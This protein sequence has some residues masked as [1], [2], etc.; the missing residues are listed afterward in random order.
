MPGNELGSHPIDNSRG[1]MF[2]ATL[3]PLPVHVFYKHFNPG[4]IAEILRVYFKLRTTPK[5][6]SLG[7]VHLNCLSEAGTWLGQGSVITITIYHLFITCHMPGLYRTLHITA[8][9]IPNNLMG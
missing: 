9:G 3:A 2:S 1:R 6:L 4:T 8:Y 7:F 5:G